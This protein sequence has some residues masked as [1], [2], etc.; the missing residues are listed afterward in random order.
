MWDKRVGTVGRM[1][2]QA[3]GVALRR[4]ASSTSSTQHNNACQQGGA[5]KQ[6]HRV[7][8]L[9]ADKSGTAAAQRTAWADS[10]RRPTARRRLCAQDQ[11]LKQASKEG[12]TWEADNLCL[13]LIK[14]V[15]VDLC[16]ELL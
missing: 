14:I 11:A 2:E 13:Y 7:G 16:D 15:R 12:R 9:H 10:P 6:A 4:R 1:G 8:Q 5:T 3:A